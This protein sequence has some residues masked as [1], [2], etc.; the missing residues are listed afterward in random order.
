MRKL[1]FVLALFAAPAAS[2]H[3]SFSA[4]FDSGEVIEIEG[5]ITRVVWANPHVRF[6]LQASGD[7]ENWY[8]ES[9]SVSILTR[10]QIGRDLL[11]PGD[12]VKL[13][14]HPSRQ[15][16]NELFALNALLA[17]GE[18]VVFDPRGEP[19]WASQSVGSNKYWVAPESDGSKGGEGI[20]RVW[21][22]VISD[23]GSFPLLPR[24]NSYPLTQPAKST[25]ASFD[26]LTDAPTL[27]CAPKGMPTIME[28]PY[29]MEFVEQD[30]SILLRL[31]EYDT[32]RTIHL[33]ANTSVAEQPSSLLGYSVGYWEKETLVVSTTRVS[34]PHFDTVGIPLSEAVEITERFT[35]SEDGT[36]LN[37]RLRVTDAATFTEPVDIEKYWL[38]VP[39]VSV[40]PYKCTN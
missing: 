37:Y 25:L 13:A 18:E 31:E 15:P 2:A 24:I 35:P 12:S 4:V 33:D 1:V 27:N 39:N 16:A 11:K 8:I 10:M 7:N 32:I 9:H 29:P 34:W 38:A 36:R 19:R 5:K 14:G 26:P 28:Q 17:N 23:K 20:F 30:A 21:S 6:S 40:Q 22:T 3:H